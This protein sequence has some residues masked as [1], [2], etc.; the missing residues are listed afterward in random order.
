MEE[1]GGRKSRGEGKSEEEKMHM[2][3]EGRIGEREK[4]REEEEMEGG[5]ED[6]EGRE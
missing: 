2:R 1:E 3:T 6:K 4:I 5:R